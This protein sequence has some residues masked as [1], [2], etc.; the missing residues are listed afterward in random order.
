MSLKRA[1][2]GVEYAGISTDSRS[3]KKGDL[4]VA[5]TGERFDGHDFV[6]DAAAA[7]ATGVVVSRPVSGA[8]GV[9][10]YPV[11]DTLVAFGDLARHRRR[12][13]V[14]DVVAVTGS[15]G[16]TTTKELLKGALGRR[17]R[18]HVT[19]MNYNNRIGLP[20]TLLDAPQD[21]Q[22]VV[23]EMGTNEPGEIEILTDIAEPG[24]GVLTT[25]GEAHLEKLGSVEGVFHEKLSLIRGLREPGVGVVSDQPPTL[26]ERA[27]A[28]RESIRVAGWSEAAD[29]DLR[30]EE[31][32]A[33]ARGCFHF[34]WKG[35]TV[36][37]RI[38]GRH[39]VLDALLALAVAEELGV[40][41]AA[42]ARG[43]GEV[44]SLDMR[45]E[46]R[47]VGS[48]TVI[49][50]CYNANPESVRAALEL[51]AT[52]PELGDRVA[53][54]GSMLELGKAS[55]SLHEE[56]LEDAVERPLDL[57]VAVGHFAVA[58]RTLGLTQ[59]TEAPRVVAVDEVEE[60]YSALLPELKGG[61][62]VLLKASRG[63]E[64]ERLVPLLEWDFGT[65][66][67][68]AAR[69]ASEGG[70]GSGEEAGKSDGP[71]GGNS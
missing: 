23:V 40:P 49:L 21:A 1:D 56:V 15:S 55:A 16:K 17:Y 48:L 6:A 45:G 32:E 68:D 29:E 37:L 7:G 43:L 60:A 70:E 8:S 42:A 9:R 47:S 51:L 27:R 35:E 39:A 46:I 18:V 67:A 2:A 62:V 20:R 53:V 28:I 69:E 58:A 59:R 61:E 63:V 4:F 64:L 71:H 38:P 24:Y 14:A 34:R 50:D 22:V 52:H 11:E 3:V 54:L 31:P 10:L 12:A 57:V 25:V 30:P 33:D 26:P 5:L 19:P 36:T 41:A 44:E 66:G 13:L 65:D